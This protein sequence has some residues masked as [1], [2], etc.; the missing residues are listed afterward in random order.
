VRIKSIEHQGSTMTVHFEGGAQL[1]LRVRAPGTA[2]SDD[3][4]DERGC[5]IALR[6]VNR[7]GED[8]RA[9]GSGQVVISAAELERLKRTREQELQ[10]QQAVLFEVLRQHQQRLRKLQREFERDSPSR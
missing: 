1:R 4:D 6:F 3:E 2:R 9:Y 8:G 5:E 10:V 7:P